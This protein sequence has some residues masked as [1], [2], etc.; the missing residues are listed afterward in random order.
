MALAVHTLRRPFAL[1]ILRRPGPLAQPAEQHTLTIAAGPCTPPQR[2]QGTLSASARRTPPSDG[3]ISVHVDHERRTL[4]SSVRLRHTLS[5]L[6]VWL[7]GIIDRGGPTQR[8][9]LTFAAV[10]ADAVH[11]CGVTTV[12]AAFCWGANGSGQLGDG[13]TTGPETSA[14]GPPCSTTPAAVVGGLNFAAVSAGGAHTCGVTAAGAAYCWGSNNS[15]Q[16][17]DG[18]TTN[19]SRPMIVAGGVTFAA[20][21]AGATHTCGVTAAGAAYCWGA[22]GVGQLGDG[23]TTDRT[24][25]T[26]VTGGENFDSVSVGVGHT[27]GLTAT[28]AA[29]CWGPNG[30]G[31]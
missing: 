26:L 23:A 15:G 18:T 30:V 29:Y 6:V 8:P 17:G 11:T 25:P 1:R 10:H 28:G 19:R 22:N 7:P 2:E 24:R 16:L 31:Q 20:V 3:T 14:G 21:R 9:T 12:G 27:C 4:L 13:T 5:A